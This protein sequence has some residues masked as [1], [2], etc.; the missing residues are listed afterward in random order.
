MT[1]RLFEGSGKVF[2][3]TQKASVL[4]DEEYSKELWK[5]LEA[6]LGATIFSELRKFDTNKEYKI[7]FE[8]FKWKSGLVFEEYVLR[9]TVSINKEEK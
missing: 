2:E 5:G 8:H 6:K 4:K 7:K 1:E 3:I 9:A